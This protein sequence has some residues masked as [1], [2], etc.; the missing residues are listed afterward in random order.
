VCKVSLINPITFLGKVEKNVLVLGLSSSFATFGNTIW[1]FFFPLILERQGGTVAQ[2]GIVYGGTFLTFALLQIPA[3]AFADRFGRKYSIVIGGITST[4]SILILAF[5]SNLFLSSASYIAFGGVG[6]AFTQIGISTLI[7]ESVPR[8]KLATGFGTFTTMAGWLSMFAPLLGS[9]YLQTNLRIVLL[10]S[11][12]LY[13]CVAIVRALF[14]NETLSIVPEKRIENLSASEKSIE[15]KSAEKEQIS[16]FKTLTSNFKTVV[17]NRVLLSLTLAYSIY[18]VLFSQGSFIVTIYSAS[19]IHLSAFQ[20]GLM[21]SIFLLFDSQLR[22]P[23]G[24]LADRWNK[25]KIIIASWVGEMSLMMLFVYSEGPAFALLSF[26]AWT[27]FGALDGPAISALLTTVTKRETRGFS[28]GFF[29]TFSS[30]LSIPAPIFSGFLFSVDPKLPF[31]LHLVIDVVAF[32]IFLHL[33]R[34]KK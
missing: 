17:S 11:V 30:L 34:P 2:I 28:F 25:E 14:L 10:I 32:V 29:N 19:V 23:F 15:R 26:A 9:F 24:I 20:L 7:A 8:E 6:G 4:I 22:I 27:A 16:R 31:F 18:G 5:S 12:L 33:I 21:F 3:G 1:Y 13:A